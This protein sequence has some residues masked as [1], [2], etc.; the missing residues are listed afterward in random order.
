M[1]IAIFTPIS[2]EYGGG[3][4]KWISKVASYLAK[5][6]HTVNVHALPYTPNGRRIIKRSEFEK[7]FNYHE[8]WFHKIHGDTLYVM[9]A[10]LT[11][12]FYKFH[13]KR[14]A[15]IHSG[16]FLRNTSPPLSYGLVPFLAWKV[17]RLIG[18]FDLSKY[19]SIHMVAGK[20]KKFRERTI[21]IPNFVDTT[22]FYPR[23]NKKNR[24]TV[25]FPGRPNWVKGWDIFQEVASKV[26]AI[27]SSIDFLAVG[28]GDS[29]IKNITVLPFISNEQELSSFFSSAHIMI[30]ASRNETSPLA[31]L[32]CLASGTIV[33]SSRLDN[34]VSLGLP[35]SYADTVE[36]FINNILEL[37]EEWK[38]D[39]T[40]F[41]TCKEE[42]VASISS[43]E[44]QNVATRL[45]DMLCSPN[46]ASDGTLNEA[47][48]EQIR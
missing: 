15:G 21:R 9:Y 35:L 47:I 32:E 40:F 24:F 5:K 37:H 42:L 39:N 25:I 7:D 16:L 45:E 14:V 26:R 17:F 34:I 1:N 8:K 20:L 41:E 30:S 43:F 44:F 3:G 28:T 46:N 31:I 36:E 13:G 29:D 48:P 11:N 23:N 19:D 10:P 38:K 2:L 12:L 22:I 18:N 33:I 6:G 27:D 4:E